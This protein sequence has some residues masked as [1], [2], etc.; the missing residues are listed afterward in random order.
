MPDVTVKCPLSNSYPAWPQGFIWPAL[1]E[2]EVWDQADGTGWETNRGHWRDALDSWT[3]YHQLRM[4]SE[5]KD[6][7]KQGGTFMWNISRG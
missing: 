2:K 7:E 6:G 3:C 4:M 1:P 5:I